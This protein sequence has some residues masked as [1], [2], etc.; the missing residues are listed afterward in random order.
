MIGIGELAKQ[1]GTCPE[2]I[3]YFEKQ[4]MLPA[5]A[6]SAGGHRVY[7]ESHELALTFIL[8][9]RELGFSQAEV[10]QLLSLTQGERPCSHVREVTR[11]HLDKIRR[12]RLDLQRLE[13]FLGELIG[14]CD[15]Q[16]RA[17]DCCPVV[18]ALQQPFES[19]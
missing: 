8:R 10:K 3:R 13:R 18:D 4:G 17:E 15:E 9:A 1:T 16:P 12:R 6:R 11:Q 5:P 19:T 14:R 2:T 7:E